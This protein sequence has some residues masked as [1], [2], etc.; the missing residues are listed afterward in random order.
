[1]PKTVGPDF[2]T[3]VQLLAIGEKLESVI[4]ESESRRVY[5]SPLR[6][7]GVLTSLFCAM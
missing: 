6:S 1:M 3:R 7:T 2:W 5:P 4:D